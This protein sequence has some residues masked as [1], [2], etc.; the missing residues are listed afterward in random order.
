M[1]IIEKLIKQEYQNDTQLNPIF[2]EC[3]KI[4]ELE[5]YLNN[6]QKIATFYNKT[7]LTLA[8]QTG[9]DRLQQSQDKLLKAIRYKTMQVLDKYQDI[10][11]VKTCAQQINYLIE[12]NI[13]D[14]E[15]KIE[16]E[17]LYII[18][19]CITDMP[20]TNQKHSIQL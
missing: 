20:N 13:D 10:V 8:E 1:R 11:K 17:K 6:L 9:V 2:M 4:V 5:K 7:N 15:S 18:S 3:L 12:D 16:L 19:K 14:A